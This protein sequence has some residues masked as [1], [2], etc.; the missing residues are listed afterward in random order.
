MMRK[1]AFMTL[2]LLSACGPPLVQ[3]GFLGTPEFELGGAVVQ[4]SL[5]IPAEHGEVHLSLL[6]IGVATSAD[7]PPVEQ[8]AELDPALGAYT[9]TLFEPPPRE[10][11]TFSD[12]LPRGRLGLAVLTLYADAD[13]D[14]ILDLARDVLLGAGRQHLL[15]WSSDA[16]PADAPAARLTGPLGP[17]YQLLEQATPGRCPFVAAERGAAEGALTPVPATRPVVLTLWPTAEAV[18]V[19]APS[20]DPAAPEAPSVWTPR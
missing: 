18:V 14:G 16:I 4:S 7:G 6:W 19:P 1:L 11:T 3:D 9:M 8:R 15:A 2:A 13:G 20:L 5:R 17:G 10:A 12:L